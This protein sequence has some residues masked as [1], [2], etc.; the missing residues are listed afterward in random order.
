MSDCNANAHG[1]E[2][3][4][5]GWRGSTGIKPFILPIMALLRSIIAVRSSSNLVSW[6]LHD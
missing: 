5:P 4:V 3:R 1:E 6:A 2:K